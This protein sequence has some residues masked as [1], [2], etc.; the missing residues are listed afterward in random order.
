MHTALAAGRLPARGNPEKV[1]R[2]LF[3]LI[4]NAIRHTPADGSVTVLAE[5]AGGEIEVEVADTGSGIPAGGP[6]PRLRRVRARRPGAP[7]RG[8]G[9]GL[10][11][12]RAIVEAHGG[13][14]WLPDA[15]RAPAC[16]SA[17]RGPRLAPMDVPIRGDM[18]RLGQLLKLADVV[19]DGGEAKALLAEGRCRSTASPRSAAAASC[20]RRRRHRGRRALRSSDFQ[21]RPLRS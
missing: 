17:S 9:L 10:A 5:P 18:I 3:N 7:G 2:V 6:R 21:G 16:A 19:S 8:A 12:S 4:Q 1:Q 15:T 20:T 13:R 11:I 14:I